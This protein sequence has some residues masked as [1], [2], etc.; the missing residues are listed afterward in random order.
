MSNQKLNEVI[1]A[2]EVYENAGIYKDTK[3]ND[4]FLRYILDRSPT[5]SYQGK[6]EVKPAAN[7]YQHKNRVGVADDLLTPEQDA[8]LRHA[9]TLMDGSS[10]SGIGGYTVSTRWMSTYAANRQERYVEDVKWTTSDELR[11]L[12]K[13]MPPKVQSSVLVIAIAIYLL[14][15]LDAEFDSDTTTF[16]EFFLNYHML[17]VSRY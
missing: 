11:K 10:Q 15:E 7:G 16:N 12:I 13:A 8:E 9:L 14:R 5:P 3:R 17:I 6:M 4:K 2:F 1:D